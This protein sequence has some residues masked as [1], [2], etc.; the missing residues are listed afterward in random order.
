MGRPSRSGLGGTG[1]G[2][3]S[4]VGSKSARRAALPASSPPNALLPAGV[5]DLHTHTIHS[6]G[7]L[8][9][10]E[11][12]R[13]AA[14][15]GC[16]ALGL[17]DHA[18]Q[19]NIE[20]CVLAAA[21]AAAG[22]S[23]EIGLIVLPGVELT[24]VPPRQTAALVARARELGA[25]YVVVHGESPVEPVAPGT[26]LAAIEAGA[27]VLAHPG[28][29]TEREAELA[30]RQGVFLELSVRGGHSLG[31][32]RVAAKA[33]AAGA[34]LVVNSDAHGP[35][36]LMTPELQRA[37]ALGA[38][39][40]EDDWRR[41]RFGLEALVR[42]LASRVRPGSFFPAVRRGVGAVSAA[43]RRAKELVKASGRAVGR[44]RASV[45]GRRRGGSGSC[46]T[47]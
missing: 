29:L 43:S 24:H 11:L 8:V 30:A 37:V 33:L 32:G 45:G 20:R 21:D 7:E 27:D 35:G 14:V 2:K 16:V 15:R 9:P 46:G 41:I 19:S 40:S 44:R 42:E 28:L 26:N 1:R 4:G 6:D 22:L 18:D 13:R 31:N 39:L 47:R 5:I 10:A 12:A 3:I 25:A 23:G 34:K 17:T 36:D 38:G